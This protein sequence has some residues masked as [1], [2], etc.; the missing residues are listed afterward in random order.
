VSGDT[1]VVL[2]RHY[3]PEGAAE[4]GRSGFLVADV[5]HLGAG[6]QSGP[7]ASTESFCSF[8]EPCVVNASCAGTNAAA[9]PAKSAVA[10]MQWIAGAF[11]YTCTGG[12]IADSDTGTQ[13]PYFLT[14]NHCLSSNNTAAN[15]ETYFQFTLPCGSTSCPAQTNP[16]G[17]Q[18]LGA[19]VKATGSAGDFTLLQLSQTLPSGSVF[20]GWTNTAVANTNGVN[21]YRISHPAWAPQSYS[22]HTVDTSAPT[23]TGWPRGQRIYSRDGVGATEG[24]SSGSPVV[25]ASS[26]IVG[27]L[28]GACGF[29]PGDPC[30]NTS[31]ATVDGAF[32]YYYA[33]VAPF[34]N[35]G[36]GGCTPTGQSCTINSQ[37]CS[38]RCKGPT[39]NKTCK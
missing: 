2:L 32:A 18:R 16:G 9:N 27:Q 19:T 4:V 11:I 38:N 39:G 3:G 7:I 28:S 29:N 36:T 5:G 17:I 34:L 24:G 22:A 30:D 37:C 15:L 31:N 20:L 14:A 25:N 13:I 1:A 6:F 21:L 10:L 33:S 12:L 35:P 23:C 26:Q 8:N